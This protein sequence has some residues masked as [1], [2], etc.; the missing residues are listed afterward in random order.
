MKIINFTFIIPHKNTPDLL[1]RCIDSIPRREDI[2][3]IIIDDNSSNHIVDFD[4]FPGQ[5]DNNVEIHFLKENKGA[6]YARN[7]GLKHAKGK[8]LLFAD[9]D[10]YYTEDLAKHLD[11]IINLQY[12]IIY[13]KTL[14]RDINGEKMISYIDYM[15]NLCLDGKITLNKFKFSN[16]VPWNK[17]FSSS[18]IFKHNIKFEELPVGNDAF[19]SLIANDNTNNIL[20]KNS[21]LYCYFFNSNSITFSKR[22]FEREL[23]YLN[24]NTR[25]NNFLRERHHEDLQIPIFSPRMNMRIYKSYGIKKLIKYLYIQ[26]TQNSLFQNIK[27]YFRNNRNFMN[28]F[29]RNSR[30]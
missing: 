20:I 16:W 12:D 18:Y 13:F 7:I 5:N 28:S 3:I 27:T 1:Q 24:I 17:I 23:L 6:G 26:H 29:Y 25:I 2:Q 10:D 22:T 8:W 14:C 15:H 9:A 21:I 11:E 4:N 30:K 19:F